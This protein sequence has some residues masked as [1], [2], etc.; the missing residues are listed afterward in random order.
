MKKFITMTIL[1]VG[2][3]TNLQAQPGGFGG[4]TLTADPTS[5]SLKV[6]ETLTPVMTYTSSTRPGQQGTTTTLDNTA[7]TWQSYDESV[8]TVGTDGKITAV[9]AGSTNIVVTYNS[10]GSQWSFGGSSAYID[11][12]V[13]ADPLSDD[14]LPF[15][16]T[17]IVSGAFAADTYWYLVQTRGSKYLYYDESTGNILLSESEPEQGS[18]SSQYLW[19]FTGN[20]TDG[21]MM[22]NY[23][24]GAQMFFAASTLSN[25]E[26]LG[27]VS[28]AECDDTGMFQV[29]KNSCGGYT[30]INKGN[31]S[32]GLN[33]FNSQNYIAY[34]VSASCLSDDGSNLMFTEVDPKEY[35]GIPESEVVQETDVTLS[36]ISAEMYVGDQLTLEATVLPEDAT[37][38][39]V[40]W[41]SSNTVCCSVSNAGVVTAKAAGTAII[42]AKT[43]NGLTATCTIKVTL[44]LNTDGLCI[45]E[46]QSAN[47]DQT[48]D[49]SYNYGGWIELYNGSAK[50]INMAGLFLTDDLEEPAKWALTNLNLTSE[51][52]SQC[53][54]TYDP[55]VETSTTVPAGGY[56][57]IWFDH[58]DWRYPMMAPF[59]LDCDGGDIYITDGANVICQATYPESIA[60]CSYCRTTDGGDTWS[61]TSRPTQG[62]KNTY[63]GTN[64]F[65]STRLE[66]P[67]PSIESQVISGSTTFTVTVP[68]GATLKYTTD[69]SAPGYGN[70]STSSTGSFSASS[71]MVYRFVAIENGMLPSKVVTVSLI[72]PS[73][74][75]TL[76]IMSVTTAPGNLTDDTYGIMTQ[77]T[78][79][80]PGLG[81]SS[82]CNWNMDWDRPANV[83]LFDKS[84]K[85]VWNQEANIAICGGWSRAYEPY[86]FKVKGKKQY[87]NTSWLQYAFF[88]NKPYIKNKTLQMRNG[89]N[90][91]PANSGTGRIKDAALQTVI[92]SSGLNID[93]QSYVPVHLY[94]NGKYAGL[95]NMREP[96][97]RD[98]VYSNFGY[99]DTDVDQFEYDCDSLY[100]Q[101][102]GD[103]VA[104]EQLYDA[105]KNGEMEAVDSLLDVEEFFN[106]MGVQAYMNMSDFGYNNMKGYR[107]RSENGKF[108]FVLFDLDSSS[109]SGTAFHTSGTTA[110]HNKQYEGHNG[111]AGTDGSAE[112]EVFVIWQNILKN[113]TKMK[114][115]FV[116]QFCILNG[117]VFTPSRAKTICDSLLTNVKTAATY[118]A[119]LTG[120]TL[121]PSSVISSIESSY[122]TTNR[123]SNAIASLQTNSYFSSQASSSNKLTLNMTENNQNGRLYIN[124]LPVPTNTF[125]GSVF[126]PVTIKAEA[127]AGYKFLGWKGTTGGS[128]VDT[129]GDTSAETITAFDKGSSWKYYD[130]GSLDGEGWNES[131][132]DDS[133]WE[134][135]DAPLG[136]N[137]NYTVTTTLD[138][139]TSSS[140]KRPTYYFRK[141]F[142][143]TDASKIE[144]ATLDVDLDD[145]VAVFVNGEEAGYYNV[146]SNSPSYDE[147]STGT[148]YDNQE[149]QV[150]SIDKSLFK[151]GTNEI[152][153]EVHNVSASSSDIYLD[154]SL[155]YTLGGDTPEP[156]PEGEYVSTD[157]EYTLANTTQTLQAVFEE[158]TAEEQ[159]TTDIHPIKVNEV[160]A[161]NSIYINDYQKKDDWIELYNTTGE[162]IDLNGYYLSDKSENPTKFQFTKDNDANTIIPAH[163]FKLVWCNKKR[164]QTGSAALYAKFDLNNEDGS[165]VV[166]TSPDQTWSDTLTYT[167]M[168]GDETCGLYPN[169]GSNTYLMNLTTPDASNRMT[170]VALAQI[171]DEH[172]LE[173]EPTG[174]NDIN[175]DKYVNQSNQL[176]INV[177]GGNVTVRN[178]DCLPT[179]VTVT[180]LSGMQILTTTLDMAGGEGSV[181]ISSLS[182]GVYVATATDTEGVT[183]SIKFSVK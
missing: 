139:G 94:E 39:R 44:N 141:S 45:N 26:Q 56:N 119:N 63:W 158:M 15:V 22:H 38:H 1:L 166:I 159:G 153:I 128:S 173:P 41:T 34:W 96:N 37:Y 133:S 167:K 36:Q 102:S 24:S 146:S 54:Y 172:L 126:S 161:S 99:D 168:N 137:N 97:N 31:S 87:E 180:S 71:T 123:A 100:V 91:N 66:A 152:A 81:Q 163:G 170:E 107:P 171:Y 2:I 7:C 117:S 6:G 114:K 46:I 95:I 155:T 72:K 9:G 129:G 135:G 43:H 149:N 20:A 86:S 118:E 85:C 93:G 115:Q 64:Y 101:S 138:Y 90:D 21:I 132:Y 4:G 136:Y 106:Y 82:K 75:E 55:N 58:G 76:P 17:E 131:S 11:I 61:W 140:D 28:Q 48:L 73:Y 83:E 78:N 14:D 109:S 182:T 183:V 42:T 108:R 50:D 27:A 177:N 88:A 154:A 121:N 122:F 59:K 143:V 10:S 62:K 30:F 162:D 3:M 92:L 144:S 40:T 175:S 84:G 116:D 98:Y 156:E 105:A 174:I 181:G 69:G 18:S 25:G 89:G 68:E 127:P 67:V 16:T 60:R 47:V 130:Q 5:A 8:A 157:A 53:G 49:P 51:D 57:T 23:Q 145:G 74:T 111:A 151:T 147:Y 176:S 164:E 19:C 77:G 32:A 165:C 110:S 124:D 150:M 12:T 65:A 120:Q 113:S 160:S 134:E 13:L 178:E 125:S 80:R 169:G 112:H 179:T 148:T 33:D 142:N 103:R 35:G 104:F 52:Y 29:Y 79:G 70:G